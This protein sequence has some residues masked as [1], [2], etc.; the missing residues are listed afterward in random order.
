[1]KKIERTFALSAALLAGILSGL[2]AQAQTAASLGA[3]LRETEIDPQ[4]CYRIRDLQLRR[5]DLS[6]YLTD[7]YIAFSKPIAGRRVFAV[8]HASE[9][10]D[11]AEVLVRPPDRGE[12]SSLARYTGSPILNEQVKET[13]F[14]T[15]DGADEELMKVI[16]ES[17]LSKPAPDMGLLLGSRL[18]SVLRNIGSSFQV[19]I[20]QD[21][22]TADRAGGFFYAAFSGVSLGNFDALFDPT[23]REQLVL[24]QVTSSPEGGGFNIWASFETRAAR[25]RAGPGKSPGSLS[26]Y[27]IESV[28][29]PDFSMQCVTTAELTPPMEVRG[30]ITF[31]IAPAMEIISVQVDGAPVEVFR[32]DAVR[33]NLMGHRQ[34]QTF[35]IVLEKPMAA[36]RTYKIE[37]RHRGRVILPAGN[38]VFFVASRVNWYPARETGHSTYDLSFTL[39]KRLTVVAAGDLVEDREEGETRVVRWR[40]PAAVRLAG[41]NVGDYDK[42]TVKRSGLAVTVYSNRSTETAL[43]GRGPQVIV[44]PPA[45][46]AR[47]GRRPG[48]MLTL[49]PAPPPDPN[50]RSAELAAEISAA[51]EWYAM[52]FGPP[53][54]KTLTVSPIPGGFGQGFPG[55][56][57]IS[58]L[59]FLTEKDR[60]EAVRNEPLR[61]FYSETLPA[62]EAA[63]QWWGNLVGAATYHDE[64]I[65][66]ALANY[67]ALLVLERR[68]GPK[69][70]GQAL[71]EALRSL[72]SQHAGKPIESIGPITWGARLRG[73]SG[74]DPWRVITYDKGSWIIH[75]LRRRVGDDAFLAM[76]GTLRKR[77]EFGVVSTEQFREL[78]VE[79]SPKGLPDPQLE[80]FFDTWVY[81]TGI[82]TLELKTAVSGKSPKVTL[83]VTVNQSGVGEEFNADLPVEIWMPAAKAPIVH[84]I[85][86]S[87][88]GATLKIALRAAPARVELAP[89]NG[90][91]AVRK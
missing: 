87:S 7:G 48:E 55:L 14:I 3:Q 76:L 2:P 4:T 88:D 16:L 30:A 11:H 42:V 54:L 67:S 33:S 47:G 43:L 73:E 10:S 46:Q 52:H 65:N 77:Y 8:Y 25:R 15:T 37:F 13:V 6:L 75:M 35:L 80:S 58:T 70:M 64:W 60:P 86:T 38:D 82:P 29:E 36:G 68:R 22:L 44:L 62:H 69:A 12:R 21:L 90:V 81:S 19:R 20:V 57:Y 28:I 50:A 41:F 84:W 74:I 34:N 18:N 51:L 9:Q 83:T 66:E 79:F 78:A 39:P 40:T 85:R 56:L 23:A 24:G 17:P 89:G 71:D 53:P 91:L 49:P 32:R 45:W 59:A 61:L 31:E 1:M 72:R 26:N 27:K 5:D 63:H